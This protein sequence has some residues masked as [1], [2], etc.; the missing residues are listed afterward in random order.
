MSP[1][2]LSATCSLRL[3]WYVSVLP[4]GHVEIGKITFNP[5]AVLG[6]GCEGTFVYR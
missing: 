2:V 3:P 4:S 5:K 6:H 1:L